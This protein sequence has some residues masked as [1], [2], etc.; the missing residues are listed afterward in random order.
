MDDVLDRNALLAVVDND[1]SLLKELIGIFA[2]EY[3]RRFADLQK[4][5]AE[6]DALGLQTSAHAIKN[7]CGDFCGRRAYELARDLE[8]MGCRGDFGS[9]EEVSARLN[10]ETQAMRT[11]LDQFLKEEG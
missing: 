1:L 5:I 2:P 11:A 4:A 9:A 7:L 3:S 6:R 10:A 8:Q